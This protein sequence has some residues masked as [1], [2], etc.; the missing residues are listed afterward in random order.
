MSRCCAGREFNKEE[1]K[2]MLE[3]RLG[4]LKNQEE[5]IRKR[6]GELGF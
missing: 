4:A 2:K 1:E 5:C 6:L 3:A